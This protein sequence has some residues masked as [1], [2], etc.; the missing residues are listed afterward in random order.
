MPECGGAAIGR[1]QHFDHTLKP[2]HAIARSGKRH[3]AVKEYVE[4]V[5]V[6]VLIPCYCKLE[7]REMK[8]VRLVY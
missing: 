7:G 3:V 2:I 6:T 1:V 5:G 4:E 8:E